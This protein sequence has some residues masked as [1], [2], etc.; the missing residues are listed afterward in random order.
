MSIRGNYVNPVLSGVK[1]CQ[2][3]HKRINAYDWKPHH[4]G[5]SN[6]RG[7]GFYAK[8][9]SVAVLHL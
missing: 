7:K 2:L 8:K 1:S 3:S 5:A 6:T 4:K 9:S